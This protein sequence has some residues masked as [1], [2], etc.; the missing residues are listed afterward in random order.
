MDDEIRKSQVHDQARTNHDVNHDLDKARLSDADKD[1]TK[2]LVQQVGHRIEL[3]PEN[4]KRIFRKINTRILPV[5]LFIYFL[6]AL[7]VSNCCVKSS[8]LC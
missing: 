8:T 4:N 1:R 5:I 7:D 2:A 3:T 6:Q